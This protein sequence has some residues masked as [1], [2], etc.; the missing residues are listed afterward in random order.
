LPPTELSTIE[1]RVVGIPTQSTPRIQV[2]AANPV[3]HDTAPEGHDQA[4]AAEPGLEEGVVDPGQGGAALE[5][6]AVGDESH[7]EGA[8]AAQAPLDGAAVESEDAPA[9]HE[10]HA[11]AAQAREQLGEEPR[12]PVADR[13]GVAPLPELDRDLQHG[14]GA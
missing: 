14:T 3:A 6:L 13:D 9:G 4:V 8:E 2:A 10:N 11:P 1:R 12:E 5:T 7:P